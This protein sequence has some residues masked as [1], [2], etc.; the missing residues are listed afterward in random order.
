MAVIDLTLDSFKVPAIDGYTPPF[1]TMVTKTEANKGGL[2][3]V[4]VNSNIVMPFANMRPKPVTENSDTTDIEYDAKL[5]F[6]SGLQAAVTLGLGNATY[7]GCEIL[8]KNL[9]AYN[10]TVSKGTWSYVVPAGRY[11]KLEWNGSAWSE[12]VSSA[13]QAAIANGNILSDFEAVTISTDSSNPTIMQYDGML[14]ITQSWASSMAVGI[15][16][17]GNRVSYAGSNN[18]SLAQTVVFKKNDAIY[19]TVIGGGVEEFACYYK[20]RDYFDR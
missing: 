15:Y 12:D 8:V 6:S 14:F 11:V 10:C 9:S 3:T 20:K 18:L 16:I 4:E 17:N 7:E 13:V 1:G 2:S 5:V 19:L